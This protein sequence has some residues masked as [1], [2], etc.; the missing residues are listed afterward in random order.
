M[1]TKELRSAA[2]TVGLG[3][4]LFAAGCGKNAPC[5]TDPAQVEA[6]RAELAAASQQSE[7]G[8]AALAQAQQDK[9]KLQNDLNGLPET[10][11]LEAE[12]N[13]LKKGSGR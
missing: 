10:G 6:A 8:E 1:K 2:I 7:S 9:A 12:L 3:L 4:A 11:E 5:N 13:T